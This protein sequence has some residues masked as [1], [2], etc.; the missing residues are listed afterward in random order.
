M[1]CVETAHDID[2]E[3]HIFRCTSKRQ[4]K[5]LFKS[6]SRTSPLRKI[7]LPTTHR[8]W[9]CSEYLKFWEHLG[10][11]RVNPIKSEEDAM[12]VYLTGA[13]SLMFLGMALGALLM[14]R[15]L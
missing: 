4:D 14:Y 13:A 6:C 5:A 8:I 3:V 12:R 2:V 7:P 11:Y 9:H 1:P 15:M 10:R